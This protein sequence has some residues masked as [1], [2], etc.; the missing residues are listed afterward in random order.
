[1]DKASDYFGN[2]AIRCVAAF[3]IC[4]VI[5]E[6][7]REC[8]GDLSYHSAGLFAGISATALDYYSTLP[9]IRAFNSPSF[10]KLGLDKKY[11]ETSYIMGQHPSLESFQRR[12][13]VALGVLGSLSFVFPSIGITYL[14]ICPLIVYSNRR[15]QNQTKRELLAALEALAEERPSCEKNGSAQ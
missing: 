10:K 14:A 7:L 13:A 8:K 3:S 15:V 9:M 4:L 11:Y 6:S 5:N 1:M 2:R 12:A